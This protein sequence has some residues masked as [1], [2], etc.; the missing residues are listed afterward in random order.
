MIDH[1]V[2]ATS[3]LAASVA[4]LTHRFGVALTPGG[5]HVGLGTRNY[6]ANLG[7]GRYLEVIGPDPE[8]PN[9]EGRR[10]FGVDTVSESRLLT[11]AARVEDLDSAVQATEQAGYDA[12]PIM[13][14]SRDRGDGGRLR[15]R[16]AVPP[17]GQDL[18]GLVPFLIDWG[19]SPH[20][21]ETAAAGLRLVSLTG[22]HPRVD[23]VRLRLAA[24]GLGEVIA[25][26]EAAEPG[27]Q[28]VLDTPAGEV[29]LS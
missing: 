12:G 22:L 16:L 10:P 26:D 20:P 2:Y 29:V 24:L 17:D 27:L 28:A 23:D 11:W 6:L 7:G 13:A 3:D 4:E 25:L 19:D 1:L 18:G 8:Q 5:Q 14:M 21:A 15:W 9:H